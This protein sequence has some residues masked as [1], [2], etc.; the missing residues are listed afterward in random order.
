MD[1]LDTFNISGSGLS[2]QRSRLQTIASNLANARTTRTDAGGPYARRAPVFEATSIDSFGDELDRALSSVTVSRIDQTPDAVR[3]EHDP[4]HPDA[5]ASG[6]VAYPDI[7]V[8]SEMVDLMTTSRSY[9]AN[10]NAVDATA[11]MA[12]FALEIG[13]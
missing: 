12:S 10:A 9:E 1:L 6:M 8:M 7:D 3:L 2:A 4:D 11:Q 13:R 5:D